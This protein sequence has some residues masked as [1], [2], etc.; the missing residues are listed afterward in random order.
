M[1]FEAPAIHWYDVNEIIF[2]HGY[3]PLHLHIERND[4]VVDIGA[5]I[6]IFTVF[7]ASITRKTVYAFE[8]FPNNFEVLRKI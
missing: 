4:I 7:A 6:G 8:P 2:I 5:N 3:N 1:Y